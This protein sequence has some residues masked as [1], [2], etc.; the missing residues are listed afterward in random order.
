MILNKKKIIPSKLLKGE[1]F[2]IPAIIFDMITT[3]IGH[4]IGI[5]EWNF[6]GFYAVYFFNAVS[7]IF[8]LWFTKKERPNL[9]NYY[10]Y[11]A[12][13]WRYSIGIWNIYVIARVV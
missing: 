5:G 11:F 9:F 3:I 8:W 1:Y 7:I 12:S 13:F 2:L 10:L 4:I 6:L